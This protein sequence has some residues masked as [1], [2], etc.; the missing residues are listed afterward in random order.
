MCWRSLV[1]GLTAVSM[2]FGQADENDGK[3]RVP[4]AADVER[5]EI[6]LK[7]SEAGDQHVVLF[8][9]KDSTGSFVFAPFGISSAT[10]GDHPVQ[11]V[12]GKIQVVGE[13]EELSVEISDCEMFSGYREAV[14][15]SLDEEHG[16]KITDF[17]RPGFRVG[18]FDVQTWKASLVDMSK[19]D[20]SNGVLATTTFRRGVGKEV[21]R[22]VFAVDETLKTALQSEM[23]ADDLVLFLEVEY[24]TDIVSDSFRIDLTL[25]EAA[26]VDYHTA[27]MGNEAK[28]KPSFILATG[29]DGVGSTT[30]DQV[31][32]STVQMSV[33]ESAKA[34]IR[35]PKII[36]S[37]AGVMLQDGLK[38]RSLG[39]LP[40]ESVGALVLQ[41]GRIITASIGTLSKVIDASKTNDEE[42]IRQAISSGKVDISSTNLKF[43]ISPGGPGGGG[44]GPMDPGMGQ[45]GAPR[46]SG[47]SAEIGVGRS[48]QTERTQA[49]EV[50]VQTK[51]ARE[52][53]KEFGGQA[54]GVVGLEFDASGKLRGFNSSRIE[55]TWAQS[56]AGYA[57]AYYQLR[58]S[59]LDADRFP[60]WRSHY[61][62]EEKGIGMVVAFPGSLKAAEAR[63]EKGMWL[64]C[65]GDPVSKSEY[66][67]LCLALGGTDCSSEGT[68][69]LPDYRGLFLRGLDSKGKV[70]ETEAGR[71]SG[72]KQD[73]ATAIP[74][75]PNHFRADPDEQVKLWKR[76]DAR[77]FVW[78]SGGGDDTS[79]GVDKTAGEPVVGGSSKY[80]DEQKILDH[81]SHTII[82]GNKETRPV[83]RAVIYMIKAR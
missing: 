17:T 37:L 53:M 12:D 27:V 69:N 60:T 24:E 45:G 40:Q 55:A 13:S 70:V 54:P 1:I 80:S 39:E 7:T 21:H 66:P 34:G 59:F 35:D 25:T 36:T 67:D 6:T 47:P 75:A 64:I 28:G 11:V 83:N 14:I 71:T 15:S 23:S 78:I 9:A 73:W 2:A 76:E 30:L 74:K 19:G 20:P 16:I 61:G 82:G 51:T 29:G 57:T 58:F 41:S 52:L 68:F 48:K 10:F 22:L 79:D 77:S 8:Y 65:D 63:E 42:R 50:E 49:E 3:R 4:R 56:V 81:H 26:M 33:R 32:S 38:K 31:L 72:D 46:S 44:S 5:K 43:G 18:S 62:A